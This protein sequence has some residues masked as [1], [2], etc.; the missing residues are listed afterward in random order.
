MPPLPFTDQD[1]VVAFPEFAVEVPHVGT[2]IDKVAYRAARDAEVLAL[3]ILSGA[4]DDDVDEFDDGLVTERFRRELQGMADVECP[5]I[6]RA[7]DEPQVRM[8]GSTNHV[9]YTEPFMMGGTLHQRLKSGPL[10]L[11][12]VESLAIALLTAVDAMWNQG[13]IVH[14]DIKPKNIG[15]AGDGSPVLLDLGIALFTEM[16]DITESSLTGPG[17][18]FYAAPEQFLPKNRST[19]DFRTDLFQIGIVLVEALTGAHPFRGAADYYRAL[20][21]FDTASLS[22]VPITGRLQTA[23]PRLLAAHQSRRFRTTAMALA[24]LGEV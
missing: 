24:S 5:H 20:T 8:I 9:W 6:I 16:S 7:V 15:F 23:I 10:T 21:N 1:V 17:S 14:R 2:G 22:S 4:V 13:R 19:I 12:E 18:Q 3:K 11:P